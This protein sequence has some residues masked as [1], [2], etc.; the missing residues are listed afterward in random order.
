MPSP[1]FLSATAFYFALAT[2]LIYIPTPLA[3]EGKLTAMSTEV[4]A[5]LA[6]TFLALFTR[7]IAY[8]LICLAA[9]CWHPL[10]GRQ[11]QKGFRQGKE[12]FHPNH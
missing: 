7:P 12:I 9:S 2:L 11:L 8:P 4:K 6:L 3:T 10:T 1:S 5:I